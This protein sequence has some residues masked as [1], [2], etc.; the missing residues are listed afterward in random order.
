MREQRL[1]NRGEPI[2]LGY[3]G[4]NNA[5][6]ISYDIPDDWIE[7]T[8]QIRNVRHG[9]TDADAYVPSQ[10]YIEDGI[11]YWQVSSVDTAITGTGV[12]QYCMVDDGTIVKSRT[13]ETIVDPSADNTETPVEE[14]EKGLIEAALELATESASDAAESATAANEAA[15]AAETAAEIAQGSIYEWF[16]LSVDTSTGQ[17]VVTENERSDE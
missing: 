9:E 1:T 16:T 11:A 17:L 2:H 6:L 7:G 10:F 4:E 15:E 8:V 3:R 5:T 14:P 12:A 13:F